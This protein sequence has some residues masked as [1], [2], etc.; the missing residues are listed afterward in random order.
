MVTQ[1]S[2]FLPNRPNQL[3]KLTK[4]LMEVDVNIRAL[5]ISETADYGIVR[6]IVSDPTKAQNV[7]QG[8]FL[9]DQTDVIA[10]ELKD[11]P[12][13]LHE[14]ADVLG[15]AN[16][17]IEYLYAFV[18]KQQNAILIIRVENQM[19]GKAIDVLESKAIKI[20][21]AEEIYAL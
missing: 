9:I 15:A 7:L 2:V 18:A 3:S 12:G 13:G 21:S 4:L 16:I 11:K 6:M 17:N 20:Y 10:V 8:E 5:T 19:R 1:I 14:I